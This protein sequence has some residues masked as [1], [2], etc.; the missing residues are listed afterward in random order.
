VKLLWTFLGFAALSPTLW[1]DTLTLRSN[2]EINGQIQYEKEAFTVTAKYKTG[3]KNFTF[4][5]RE[6][7]SLEFNAR[8]FNPGEPPVSVS[9]FDPSVATTKDASQEVSANINNGSTEEKKS[10][11]KQTDSSKTSPLA[12]DSYE[13]ATSDV[14]WLRDKTKLVGRVTLIQKGYITIQ[15]G[16]G[17]KQ[18]EEQKAAT[19]LVAPD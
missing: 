2:I 9:T 12:S 11:K 15:I 7:R 5:R 19:V 3:K 4:D 14:I 13:L 8:D 16:K 10:G 18:V 6:V 17:N 1:A